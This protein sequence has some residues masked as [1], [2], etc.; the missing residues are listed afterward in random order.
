VGTT[1]RVS[2]SVSTHKRILIAVV[3]TGG[4]CIALVLLLLGVPTVLHG[5]HEYRV[6]SGGML[7][8]MKVRTRFVA[9]TKAYDKH[10]PRVGDVIVFHPPAGAEAYGSEQ[11]G[12]AKREDQPC[13]QPT[14][15]ALR[16][17][18][19]KRVVAVGPASVAIEHG[20]TVLNGR[21]Q[22]EPFVLRCGRDF[23]ELCEMP[24]PI[25][26]PKGYVFL[27]GDNRGNSDDARFWGP[28]PFSQVIGRAERCGF[29]RL[30]CRAY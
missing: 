20:L 5:Y 13:P 25:T 26:V 1:G 15:R 7:P 16:E 2:G 3:L 12:V 30:S 19:I 29:L 28:I 17:V 27:L 23:T 24:R 10:A 4:S 8:T 11:C 9:D 14:R 22:R 21:T 18:F 6:P